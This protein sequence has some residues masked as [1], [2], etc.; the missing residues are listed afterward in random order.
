MVSLAPSGPMSIYDSIH[1]L[2]PLPFPNH[3][4]TK[5]LWLLVCAHQNLERCKSLDVYMLKLSHG[6]V[7]CE[8]TL[9][10]HCLPGL[11][12]SYISILGFCHCHSSIT[13]TQNIYGSVY[14]LIRIWKGA[15]ILFVWDHTAF[16]GIKQSWIVFLRKT[17]FEKSFRK[18][19][20]PFSTESM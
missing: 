6:A 15:S 10:G 18:M 9:G 20:P 7:V 1:R 5:Y 13:S 19:V 17:M 14:V 3:F 11:L 4:N 12:G 8:M 2:L 16:N